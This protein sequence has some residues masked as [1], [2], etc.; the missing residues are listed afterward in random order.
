MFTDDDLR[1]LKIEGLRLGNIA[2]DDLRG[3]IAR[4]KAAEAYANHRHAMQPIEC[5]LYQEW[6]KAAGK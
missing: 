1:R 6:L 2:A 4:L 3:L 5:E